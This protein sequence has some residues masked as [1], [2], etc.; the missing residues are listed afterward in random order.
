MDRSMWEQLQNGSDVRGDASRREGHPVT[1]G[2]EEAACIGFA[3]GRWIAQSEGIAPEKVR[4]AVGR[5]CRLSGPKLALAAVEGLLAAG[6][7]VMDVGPA[8]TPAMFMTTQK[9]GLGAHGAI[10]ITA[11]HLPWYRNGMKFFV[12]GGG[13]DHHQVSELIAMAKN[14]QLPDQVDTTGV[15]AFDFLQTYAL[16]LKKTLSARVGKKLALEGLHVVVDAGNGMGGFFERLVR[17]LG[18]KTDGS[19]YLKPDGNFP[20][21]VPNPEDEEAMQSICRATL[22]AGADIG[23]I[24]DTDCDRVAFVDRHGN[25][26]SRNRLIALV[27]EIWLKKHPGGTIVTDS[28]TSSGLGRFIRE[29]GGVHHRYRRGYKNVIDEA[30]RLNA[31]GVDCPVAIE[32][33]GHAAL[34]ENKFLDDGAYLAV[35]ILAQLITD[36]GLFEKLAALEEPLEERELRLKV[37]HDDVKAVGAAAMAALEGIPG[38]V[39]ASDSHE[40]V[41][42]YLD[43]GGKPES[44]WV[45]LRVSLHDPVLPVNLESDVAGGCDTMR[46]QLRTALAPVAGVDLTPL[47]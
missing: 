33:S 18:A 26:I 47:Q 40:G 11:S 7:E 32:T 31:E 36:P 12:S 3:F 27:A 10:M 13:L 39:V 42:V 2:R 16:S 24:L 37:T 35:C 28:V 46:A 5:D 43:V 30:V 4:V 6:V 17:E 19:C 23:I 29:L 20:N 21:H 44:S 34:R 25:P 45:M 15:F 22:A 8:T 14:A 9:E 38:A 1:L 41:R